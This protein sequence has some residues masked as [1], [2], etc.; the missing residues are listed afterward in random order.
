[1]HRRLFPFVFVQV[2]S[3]PASVNLTW[4]PGCQGKVPPGALQGGMSEDGE[5]LYIARVNVDGVV[6]VGKVL[7]FQWC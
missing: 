3:N 4:E 2:L 6:S 5:T 7:L 1:M